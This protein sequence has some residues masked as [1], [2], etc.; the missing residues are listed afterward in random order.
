MEREQKGERTKRR[1]A[2]ALLS[3]L[4]ERPIGTISIRM[5]TEACGLDRQTFYYHFADIYALLK[6][7][8]S[9]SLLPTLRQ[10]QQGKSMQM[11]LKQ[12]MGFLQKNKR[13]VATL[14]ESGGRPLLREALYADAQGAFG[15]TVVPRL[16][17]AGVS[18][19]RA[20]EAA[21]TCRRMVV[22]VIIDWVEGYD[23]REPEDL[24]RATMDDVEDYLRGVSLHSGAC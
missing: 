18:A 3:L 23:C 7:A 22:S 20:E 1:M 9:S 21:Q 24:V 12:V 17:E 11:S 13:A 14:L 2:E 4:S 19:R 16:K 5:I 10:A 6:F 8:F 15:A